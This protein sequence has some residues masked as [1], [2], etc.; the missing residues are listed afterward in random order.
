MKT[1]ERAIFE[2]AVPMYGIYQ[3]ESR[4]V[5]Y[6]FMPYAH[7]E[8][9]IKRGDYELKMISTIPSNVKTVEDFFAIHNQDN[10]PA[11]KYMRS[12]SMSDVLV[13][14]SDDGKVDA[15]YVNR[16]GFVY[17]PHFLELPKAFGVRRIE[18]DDK[19]SPRELGIQPAFYIHEPIAV[20]SG[21][22]GDEG[23]RCYMPDGYSLSMSVGGK[24]QLYDAEKQYVP[25]I[26]VE[27]HPAII[28]GNGAP[29]AL[30]KYLDML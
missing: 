20:A 16:T 19:F 3:I 7:A 4:D 10:R 8:G 12:M 5:D 2:S 26:D 11:G 27:G 17:L 30:C 28:V 23:V 25:I 6:M 29:Y 18:T 13:K 24:M 21:T 14:K 1:L 9:K 15:F 22:V